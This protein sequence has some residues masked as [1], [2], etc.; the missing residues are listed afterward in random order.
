MDACKI[1]IRARLNGEMYRKG[2]FIQHSNYLWTV[3]F[4]KQNCW[5]KRR[6]L[7]YLWQQ[8]AS[9]NNK[10]MVPTLWSK[11]IAHRHL[12]D[13]FL[14][15]KPASQDSFTNFDRRQLRWIRMNVLGKKR[16]R[17][18]SKGKNSQHW[19]LV[20]VPANRSSVF[21]HCSLM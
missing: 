20:C 14:L 11:W 10:K 12:T 17:H 18:K 9:S 16:P 13:I 8:L 2:G 4:S 15:W 3:E 19:P 7:K 6:K 5:K 21:G 1:T